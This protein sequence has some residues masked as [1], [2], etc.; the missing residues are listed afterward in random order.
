[1]SQPSILYC[2]CTY[3]QVV[4]AEVRETVLQK[5]CES[6]RS[7]EAVADLC[8]LSARKDPSLQNLANNGAVKI[9]ACYPRALKWL[10]A[11]PGAPLDAAKTEVLNMREK[12]ADE[13]L[14]ALLNDTLTPNL[15][16]GKAAPAPAEPVAQP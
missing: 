15:P 14:A 3:A 5:L 7:F 6:G 13:I 1:M 11:S 8:E 16:A 9:A 4:P 2:H 10:F 12:P